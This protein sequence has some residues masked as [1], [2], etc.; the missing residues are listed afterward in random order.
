MSE[1]HETHTVTDHRDVNV[2]VTPPLGTPAATERERERGRLTLELPPWAR[3]VGA[4]L[5]A[6]LGGSATTVGAA[7]L[8]P[9]PI[10]RVEFEAL[11]DL[12]TSSSGRLRA[13]EDDLATRRADR[14]FERATA[15]ADVETLKAEVREMRDDIKALTVAVGARAWPQALTGASPP[16]RGH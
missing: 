3:L 14:A 8:G 13:L 16:R 4:Y 2:N 6:I 5:L 11:R 12:A 15:K 9:A 10:Q 1:L 7:H